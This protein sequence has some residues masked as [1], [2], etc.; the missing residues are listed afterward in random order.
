METKT[1]EN[2]AVIRYDE[3]VKILIDNQAVE[4]PSEPFKL[5]KNGVIITL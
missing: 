5:V 2:K 1:P 3:L 4:Q